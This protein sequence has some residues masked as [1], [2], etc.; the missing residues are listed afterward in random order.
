MSMTDDVLKSPLYLV[1]R[2]TTSTAKFTFHCT[3]YASE[4]YKAEFEEE[5]AVRR[6]ERRGM[7]NL[8]QRSRKNSKGEEEHALHIISDL[9]IL[10]WVPAPD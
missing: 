5:L 4:G 10:S 7:R 6:A 9:G 2:C 3:F 8:T 1:A